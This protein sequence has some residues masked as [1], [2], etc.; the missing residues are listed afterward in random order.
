VYIESLNYSST[1]LNKHDWSIAALEAAALGKI[2]I[3]N[4][5]YGRGMYESAY[6]PHKL[7]VANTEEELEE[8]I[9]RL[10]SMSDDELVQLKQDTLDW[11]TKAHSLKAI[12][13]RIKNGLGL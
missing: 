11:V 9:I 8:A 6:G 12:G 2:V 4:F 1:S 5:V 13:N 3:T 10:L 7:Q